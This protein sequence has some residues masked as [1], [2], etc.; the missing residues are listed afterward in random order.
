MIVLDTNVVSELMRS[1]P[2]A[3]VVGWVDRQADE[4]LYLAAWTL[5][6]IRFGIASLPQGKRRETLSRTFEEAIRPLFR[7]QI[8]GFDEAAS[9]TYAE[10]RARCRSNGTA[11]SDADAHIAAVARAHRCHIATRDVAPFRAAGL[12]VVNPFVSPR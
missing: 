6:E 12:H 10:L 1:S 9:E 3:S 2:S 8:L 7:D 4:T 5:A 11:I